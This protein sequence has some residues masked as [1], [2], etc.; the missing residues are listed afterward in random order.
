MITLFKNTEEKEQT[1]SILKDPFSKDNVESIHM[2]ISK[3]I[4]SKGVDIQAHIKFKNGET[5]GGQKIVADSF[6]ELISKV[7][8]FLKNI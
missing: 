7:E 6:P 3:K 5:T 2:F 8:S 4:F 1:I